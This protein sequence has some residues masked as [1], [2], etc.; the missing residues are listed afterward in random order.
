MLTMHC[1]HNKGVCVS[2]PCNESELS[3]VE[4]GGRLERLRLLS[5]VHRGATPSAWTRPSLSRQHSLADFF[6]D[7]FSCLLL[8]RWTTRDCLSLLRAFKLPN[9][10]NFSIV[11]SLSLCFDWVSVS[12]EHKLS[13]SFFLPNL[14]NLSILSAIISCVDKV[15]RTLQPKSKMNS[16]YKTV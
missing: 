6:R 4:A 15:K 2:P 5:P 13:D 11:I 1:C 9:E 14:N 7:N 3:R 10:P 8:R 12:S 16:V